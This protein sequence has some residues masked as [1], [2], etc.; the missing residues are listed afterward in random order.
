MRRLT[1]LTVISVLAAGLGACTSNSRGPLTAANNP[2]L[3]SVHQPVVQN[4]NFVLDLDASGD[5]LSASERARLIGWFEGIELRYGDQIFVDEARDYPSP[6]ARA[7]VGRALGEYGMLLRDGAPVTNG[8]VAPGTV[9]VIASR[10]T[11]S[12]PGC[13]NWNDPQL[14]PSSNTSPNYG[15][16]VNSNL[17]AMVA[18]PNDLVRGRQGS[19]DSSAHTAA[20]AVRVYR[21]RQPTGTQPL[22]ATSTSSTSGGSN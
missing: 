8:S 16:A 1:S 21:E 17:A 13:P 9:R 15:C 7:D 19:V 18:D 6:G 2:S 14:G 12:V 4:T 20:R 3:Y 10:G 22:P 11:A 5:Q